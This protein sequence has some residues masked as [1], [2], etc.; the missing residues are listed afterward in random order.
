MYT[1]DCAACGRLFGAKRPSARTCSDAC[2][3]RLYKERKAAQGVQAAA[4]LQR[5]TAAVIGLTAPGATDAERAH[6]RAE[7]DAIAAEAARLYPAA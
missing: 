6:F 1:F 4:L 5:Q 3:Q 2:R 7:L